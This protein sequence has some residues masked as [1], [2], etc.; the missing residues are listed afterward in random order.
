MPERLQLL[1]GIKHETH[2]A[3]LDR[4]RVVQGLSHKELLLGQQCQGPP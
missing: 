2:A 3:I 4:Q 1:G